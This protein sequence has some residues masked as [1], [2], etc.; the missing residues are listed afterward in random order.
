MQLK[1]ITVDTKDVQAL[2]GRSYWYA[3]KVMNEIRK[4][5]G[6]EKHQLVSVFELCSYLSLPVEAAIAQLGLGR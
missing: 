3:L 1:R 4:R 6:K 5:T 2:T